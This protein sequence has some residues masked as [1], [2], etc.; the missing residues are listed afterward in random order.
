MEANTEIVE[1]KYSKI[2]TISFIIGVLSFSIFIFLLFYPGS[3]AYSDRIS[4]NNN[5]FVLNDSFKRV[6]I[7]AVGDAMTHMP[8][9]NSTWDTSCK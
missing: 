1:K 8:V 6:T 5:P 4:N 3:G 9:I 2:K 7:L